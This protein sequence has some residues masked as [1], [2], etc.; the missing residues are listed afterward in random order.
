MNNQAKFTR[1]P[2]KAEFNGY[3]WE[4]VPENATALGPFSIG[5]VCPSDP[6]NPKGGLQEANAHLFA[7]APEMYEALEEARCTIQ[8]L[9]DEGYTGYVH[10]RCRIDKALAKAQGEA[11]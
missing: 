5:N 9:V 4:V 7:A 3:F 10:Q 6:D 1:G 8:A 11:Q 2:Y